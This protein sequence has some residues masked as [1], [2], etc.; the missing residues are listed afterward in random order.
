MMFELH[1]YLP[2]FFFLHSVL[3]PLDTSDSEPT[4]FGIMCRDCGK[5]VYLG[6]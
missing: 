3:G 5:Q 1:A 4:V 6:K 2:F